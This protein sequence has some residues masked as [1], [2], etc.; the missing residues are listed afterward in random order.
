M[1]SH[2]P[3]SICLHYQDGNKPFEIRKDKI[4]QGTQGKVKKCDLEEELY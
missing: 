2:G 3:A 4:H 1:Y